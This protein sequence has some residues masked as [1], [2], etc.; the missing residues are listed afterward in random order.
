[1][2]RRQMDLGAR[3]DET[4]KAGVNISVLN[5]NPPGPQLY[6]D[7]FRAESLT[8]TRAK[9]CAISSRLIPSG[10]GASLCHQAL[11]RLEL[12][13]RGNAGFRQ[14]RARSRPLLD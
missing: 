9:S 6:S 7:A 10:V 13:E 3:L 4:I 1:M 14:D 8:T 11:H 12:A 5:L 2:R